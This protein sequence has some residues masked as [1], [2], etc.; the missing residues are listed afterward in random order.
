M[1]QTRYIIRVANT[2]LQGER[3]IGIALRKI[4]GVGMMLSSAICTVANIDPKRK[5][6]DLT[7]AEEARL[8]DVVR[9]PAKF[10]IPEWLLNRRKDP[11]TGED[12]HLIG[13]D[14]HYERDND[15]KRMRKMRTYKGLRHAEGLTVRGQRTK[16]NFRKNKKRGSSKKSSAP[17]APP[18]K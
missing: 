18:Q 13:S 17:R 4:R 5:A 14:V 3:N 1:A 2:D 9:A 15:I 16:S 7:E 10:G 12:K 11:E 6:G 8:N